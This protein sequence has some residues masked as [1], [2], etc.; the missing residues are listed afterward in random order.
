V[1]R[2]QEDPKA[3]LLGTSSFWEGVDIADNAMKVLVVARLPFNVPTEPVFAARSG[4]YEQPFMQYAVP[5]A[6]LR[7]RQGF[8]RLIRNK[9]DRGVVVVLDS[10]ITSKPYGR[11]FL[12]SVP[13]A[14]V[15]RGELAEVMSG[16]RE[17]L[18]PITE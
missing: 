14:T 5:Q 15:L 13:P 3:V 9:S 10:R 6:V 4:L 1:A 7:F 18:G 12:G 11:S 16:V 8:G 17:W 2:F